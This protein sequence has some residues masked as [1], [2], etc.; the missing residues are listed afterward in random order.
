MLTL[1]L[2]A[3]KYVEGMEVTSV[4]YRNVQLFSGKVENAGGCL[5]VGCPFSHE[6]DYTV[7]KGGPREDLV[8]V[9]E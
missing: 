3:V 4:Q 7:T 5:R 8:G 2:K 1:H 9:G 6:K